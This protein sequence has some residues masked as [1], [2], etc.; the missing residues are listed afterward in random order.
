L[1]RDARLT[2]PTPPS[3]GPEPPRARFQPPGGSRRRSRAGRLPALALCLTAALL[4]AGLWAGQ[5]AGQEAGAEAAR[6]SLDEAIEIALR[7]G[8]DRQA[9][10]LALELAR[11]EYEQAKANLLVSP[12][13]VSGRE[14]ESAW[15]NAQL[16]HE[17]SLAS[18]TLQ[19]AEAYY[20]L[21]R[22]LQQVELS[23]GNLEQVQRQLEA[24]QVRHAAGALA[25]LDLKQTRQ[26]LRQAEMQLEADQRAL[27]AA[28]RA[29]NQLLGRPLDE[30][31]LPAETELLF[32][33]VP[34]DL[35]TALASA[36][37]QRL[38][39]LQAQD[40]VETARITLEL[41]QNPFTPRL[42]QAR[43]ELQLK[44]AEQALEQ[45]RLRVELEVR[46]AYD[47]LQAAAAQVP[48]REAAAELAAEQLRITQ[49]RFEAGTITSL[50]VTE[51]QQKAFE[52]QV[53]VLNAL[54]DYRI[55]LARFLQAAQLDGLAGTVTD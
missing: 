28:Q 14:A 4:T 22:S 51:A 32:E 11:L 9:A 42:D 8:P 17:A 20:D 35:E 39:I 19:V 50:D 3:H 7:Q 44:Q 15:R 40:R 21:I 2:L 26:Q 45:A 12:S 6:L 1:A 54:F 38:E 5:A 25:D 37:A 18:L 36:L 49:L 47:A 41:A 53:S 24:A 48:L 46:N 55:S 33:P 10:D 31:V 43:A 30:P 34:V 23:Q 27:V 52:A 16:E 29:L 13:P